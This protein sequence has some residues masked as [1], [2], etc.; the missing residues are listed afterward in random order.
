MSS[1]DNLVLK[2]DTQ[3]LSLSYDEKLSQINLSRSLPEDY[4][5]H[6]IISINNNLISNLNNHQ[7]FIIDSKISPINSTSYSLYES[8]LKP[9]FQIL[10]INYTYLKTNSSNSIKE[11][12]DLINNDFEKYLILSISGDTTIFEFINYVYSNYQNNLNNIPNLTIL[13]F[14]HGTGNALSISMNN[15][16]DLNSI[17]K[18]FS[19]N[20]RHLPIYQLN[21]NNNLIPINDLL[22]TLQNKNILFTVVASWC[23]HSTL[24]YESDKPELRN[25][26]GSERFRIAA[27]KILAENP[28]FKGK[29]TLQPDNKSF[30]YNGNKWS[31]DSINSNTFTDLSYLVVA[32][33]PNFEKTFKI[34]PHSTIESDELHLITIPLVPSDKTISLM[35]DAYNNGIHINNPLVGYEKISKTKTLEIEIDNSMSSELSIICLDGSSWEVTGNDRKLSITTF[36]QSFLYYLS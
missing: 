1:N 8:V 33:V 30:I 19:W 14:P 34:S 13:P 35:N 11:Y 31:L 25:N 6:K 15:L 27:N 23:L 26:Y 20:Q 22:N 4:D 12:A 29:I 3:Y 36:D 28:V 16:N 17:E 32:A 21:S 9:I 2:Y 5:D 18:L 7:I 10:G 24:V